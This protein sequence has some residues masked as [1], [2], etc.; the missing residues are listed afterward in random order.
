[1]AMQSMK[2][3]VAAIVALILMGGG[4]SAQPPHARPAHETHRPKLKV[5]HRKAHGGD[6]HEVT[7]PNG[8]KYGRV[9]FK[10]GMSREV[11][12]GV[13]GAWSPA[14]FPPD[15]PP[16]APVLPPGADAPVPDLSMYLPIPPTGAT[17][18][19]CVGVTP[20]QVTA[21]G[22]WDNTLGHIAI[23]IDLSNETLARSVHPLARVELL[24][25]FQS[26]VAEEGRDFS[27][28]FNQ[29]DY[30]MGVTTEGRALRDT[31]I[32]RGCDQITLVQ[33]RGD[34]CGLGRFG[35]NSANSPVGYLYTSVAAACLE[36]NMSYLHEIG[37]NLGAGH[38]IGAAAG[39]GGVAVQCDPNYAVNGV[40]LNPTAPYGVG[41][42]DPGG[43][44]RTVMS[45][46]GTQRTRQL[47]E[48]PPKT[49]YGDNATLVGN[50]NNGVPTDEAG[51][52]RMTFYYASQ[53]KAP[54]APLPGAVS[55]LKIRGQ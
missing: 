24:Y 49:W 36:S 41:W 42:E 14:T 22:N 31:L 27:G 8:R 7:L 17:L 16:V 11:I 2:T 26:P 51:C 3:W 48:P 25:A 6:L 34:Y 37:H 38:N 28:N 19:S 39:T 55:N 1:M 5:D 43:K 21:Y 54:I 29:F 53:L 33:S 52:M 10:N 20:E 46:G 23:A 13:P 15:G 30:Y 47:A 12:D 4:A 35:P 50:A 44:F 18:S 9:F 32:A 40:K 45:Y